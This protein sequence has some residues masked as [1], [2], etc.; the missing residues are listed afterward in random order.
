MRQPDLRAL[1]ARGLARRRP[2]RLAGGWHRVELCGFSC[3]FPP[4]ITTLA[5]E[6]HSC[7]MRQPAR[8]CARRYR[9]CL[10]EG[11]RRVELCGFS[12]ELPPLITTLAPEPHSCSMRQ[13]PKF[14]KTRLVALGPQLAQALTLYAAERKK[15]GWRR[16][17]LCGFSCEFPP[18][19]TTLAPEPHSCAM[20]Q[21]PIAIRRRWYGGARAPGCRPCSRARGWR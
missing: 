14:Y 5:P 4:L 13:P 3:E 19:I 18:L 16:V 7:A 1:A 9:F 2:K 21:P 20:R 12:C 11:W 6:P 8:C 10:C 15:G 17:E